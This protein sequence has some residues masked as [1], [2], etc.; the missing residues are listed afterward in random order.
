VKAVSPNTQIIAV[1]PEGAATLKVSMDA[2]TP[3]PLNMVDGFADGARQRAQLWNL[4]ALWRLRACYAKYAKAARQRA[5]LLSL[6]QA[7]M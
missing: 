1:E 4:R 6:Y 3:T 7:R 5:I 2:G